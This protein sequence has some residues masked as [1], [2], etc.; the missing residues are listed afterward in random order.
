[1]STYA[2]DPLLR[3]TSLAQDVAGTA[4]DVTSTFSY[5]PASQIAA[6]SRSNDAYAWGGAVALTRVYST[7]GLNQYTQSGP[8]ALSYDGRGNLT[9]SG[10]QSYTYTAEN[11]MKS[12]SG[13][14]G[15]ATLYYDA[16]GR[17]IE[18]DTSVSTRFAFDG[19]ELASEV[20][21]PSG[22]ILRRYVYGPG[23]D[24]P[25]VWYEGA[26]ASD[27]RWLHS[28]ERGSVVA[29]TNASGAVSA[30]NSYDDHGNPG[31]DVTP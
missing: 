10:S 8:V 18:Y 22:A 31:T 1:M 11:R 3:L 19:D 6:R 21:N 29:I 20:A 16:L 13:A 9:G 28:D 15:G 7:N 14:T 17:L 27:K 2:Y 30:I 12:A 26:G 4:Q 24:E 23:D 5:N 25:L